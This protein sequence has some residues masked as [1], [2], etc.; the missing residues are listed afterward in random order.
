[1]AGINQ[2]WYLAVLPNDP[3][4]TVSDLE[5]TCRSISDSESTTAGFTLVRWLQSRA[6]SLRHP[7]LSKPLPYL[8]IMAH[9]KLHD[10]SMEHAAFDN[11]CAQLCSAAPSGC[12]GNAEL[13]QSMSCPMPL[14]PS[15]LPMVALSTTAYGA[16][17]GSMR[18]HMDGGG[19]GCLS[20]ARFAGH[21]AGARCL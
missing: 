12:I 2:C 4:T 7:A 19:C 11:F 17:G 13:V 6:A 5:A 15:E 16:P 20:F 21:A 18:V 8:E 14:L 1:M 9:V 10:K 3:E